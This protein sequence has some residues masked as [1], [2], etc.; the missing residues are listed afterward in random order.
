MKSPFKY[1]CKDR[2]VMF[3]ATER[4]EIT[5]EFLSK[6]IDFD[7][8]STAGIIDDHFPLHKRNIVEL[9][10]ESVAHYKNK[11]L[12]GF[13]F[14]TWQKYMEPLNMIKNYYGEKYAFEYAYLLHY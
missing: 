4:V 5:E 8:F 3:D 2:F 10:G 13:L 6:E 14:G 7:Y 11:L 1:E 9:I 12:F